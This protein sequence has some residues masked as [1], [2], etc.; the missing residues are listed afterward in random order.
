MSCLNWCCLW[1]GISI[2]S[3]WAE[4]LAWRFLSA[5]SAF[6][7]RVCPWVLKYGYL[8]SSL[9]LAEFSTSCD[10]CA[11]AEAVYFSLLLC[12]SFTVFLWSGS[13]SFSHLLFLLRLFLQLSSLGEGIP[14]QKGSRWDWLC[15][16]GKLMEE[17]CLS[18]PF[19]S[20]S[21][22]IKGCNTSLVLAL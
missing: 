15:I 22:W 11:L 16:F 7:Q 10:D 9:K 19:C 4:L 8:Y 18:V 12:P 13:S 1:A 3:I 20:Y 5:W 21:L 17:Q 6:H 2:L 14:P